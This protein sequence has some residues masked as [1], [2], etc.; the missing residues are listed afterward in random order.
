[1]MRELKT[2]KKKRT[3]P[4]HSNQYWGLIYFFIIFLILCHT[5]SCLW[6]IVA[7]MQNF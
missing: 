7:R 5:L 2:K 1:M 4:D 6:Y 3:D